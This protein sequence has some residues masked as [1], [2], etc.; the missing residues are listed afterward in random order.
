MLV[1][2]YKMFKMLE[3]ENIDKTTTRFMHI[4]NQLKALSKR[5]TNA[6]MMRKILISLS[7]AWHPKVITI[8]KAKDLNVLSLD[9][10]IRSLKTHEIKLIEF[11][12]ETIRKGKSIALK[13][14]Q[15]RT[16]SSKAMKASEEFEGDEEDS[17]SSSSSSDEIA[18]LA[19]KILKAW[20]KRKKKNL[21][22]KKDKKDKT[23]QDEIICFECKEPGHVRSECPRLKKA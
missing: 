11:S 23:K 7:N 3:H 12:K 13:S 6:E 17:S 21:I 5:Y 10:L 14:T 16:Q 8:K 22:P 9:A 15:K 20:I 1:H 4:I 18:H 19:R 2:Q